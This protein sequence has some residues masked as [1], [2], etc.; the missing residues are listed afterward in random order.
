[1]VRSIEAN[2]ANLIEFKVNEGEFVKKGDEIL[3]YE[4]VY[5]KAEQKQKELDVE[6]MEKEYSAGLH[7]RQAE[8]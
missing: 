3:T 2:E 8:I 5:D 1:M 6:R 7:Q 4:C